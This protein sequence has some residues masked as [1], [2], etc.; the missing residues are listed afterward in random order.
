MP[1]MLPDDSLI[2]TKKKLRFTNDCAEVSASKKVLKLKMSSAS[3]EADVAV[4]RVWT[5]E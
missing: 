4:V 5:V 1:D 2:T 3:R